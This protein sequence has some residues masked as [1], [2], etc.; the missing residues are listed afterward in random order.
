MNE[1]IIHYDGLSHHDDS[2]FVT[3][4]T[5]KTTLLAKEEH[6]K[7]DNRRI[8]Q[9]K[10]VPKENIWG[11][12]IIEIHAIPSLQNVF[13]KSKLI[14]SINSFQNFNS[15]NKKSKSASTKATTK[16][17]TN[18]LSPVKGAKRK[19]FSSSTEKCVMKKMLH[20]FC[21]FCHNHLL[22][23]C[24][25]APR[26]LLIALFRPECWLCKITELRTKGKYSYQ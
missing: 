26:Y 25:L 22:N 12:G 3:N 14:L 11:I 17:V 5:M 16:Y 9:F 4:R 21:Q 19:H 20:F 10:L 15:V 24:H 6:E 18:G 2:V 1:C 13:A 8:F 7:W 23:Y